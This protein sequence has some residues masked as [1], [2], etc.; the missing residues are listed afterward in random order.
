MVYG[1][2][3][4]TSR[5]AACDTAPDVYVLDVNNLCWTHVRTCA[6]TPGGHPSTRALHLSTVSCWARQPGNHSDVPS[7]GR[8]C[9]GSCSGCSVVCWGSLRAAALLC[10]MALRKQLLGSV[11]PCAGAVRRQLLCSV[12]S[13]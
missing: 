4:Y 10:R 9:A 2:E 1:G 11:V 5:P 3:G 6:A 13:V 12:V 8:A 7:C